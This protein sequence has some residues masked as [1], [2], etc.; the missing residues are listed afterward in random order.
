MIGLRPYRC[1]SCD[2]RFYVPM[3]LPKARLTRHIVA[4][5]HELNPFRRVTLRRQPRPH[6]RYGISSTRFSKT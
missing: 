6:A 4:L 3:S 5:S 2:H 1:S